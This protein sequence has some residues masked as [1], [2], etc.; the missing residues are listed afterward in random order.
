MGVSLGGGGWSHSAAARRAEGPIVKALIAVVA[1]ELGL[2]AWRVVDELERTRADHRRLQVTLFLDHFARKR[3]LVI[4][5]AVVEFTAE[6][7]EKPVAGAPREEKGKTYECDA[8]AERRGWE[9]VL[10]ARQ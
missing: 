1:D 2:D 4:M 10:R 7:D 9:I 3:Y 5:P 8:A 6:P